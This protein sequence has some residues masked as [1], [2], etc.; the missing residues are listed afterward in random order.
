MPLKMNKSIQKVDAC[1]IGSGAGGGVVA[2][3]LAEKG[4]NVVVLEAGRRFDPLRDYTAARP[5]WE[6]ASWESADRFK[7]PSLHKVLPDRIGK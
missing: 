4:L 6:I 2:K 1:I 7:V 3:E 5:D